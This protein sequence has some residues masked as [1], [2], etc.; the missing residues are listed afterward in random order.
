MLLEIDFAFRW[1]VENVALVV[2]IDE[3]LARVGTFPGFDVRPFLAVLV[4]VFVD[5]E[6]VL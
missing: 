1:N 5:C 4:N 3:I 2:F 6:L